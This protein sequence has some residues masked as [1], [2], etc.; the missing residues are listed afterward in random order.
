MS[1]SWMMIHQYTG[2]YNPP[3]SSTKGGLNTAHLLEM[4]PGIGRW[5]EIPCF[6]AVY[7]YLRW[8][9]RASISCGVKLKKPAPTCTSMCQC[10]SNLHRTSQ[11]PITIRDV[12]TFDVLATSKRFETKEASRNHWSCAQLWCEAGFEGAVY[13]VSQQYGIGA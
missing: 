6:D 2:Y 3:Q 7:L 12:H 11:V 10:V 13:Q 8:F 9:V 4:V 5:L 1:N